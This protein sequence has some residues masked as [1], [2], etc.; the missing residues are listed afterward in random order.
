M[1]YSIDPKMAYMYFQTGDGTLNGNP[2][3]IPNFVEEGHS[4][5]WNNLWEEKAKNVGIG[6]LQT[7]NSFRVDLNN[8]DIDDINDI[9]LKM[10]NLLKSYYVSSEKYNKTIAEPYFEKSKKILEN[11]VNSSFE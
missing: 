11:I 9:N 10:V 8:L 3:K 2:K 6:Y 7:K 1:K 5:L 4:I